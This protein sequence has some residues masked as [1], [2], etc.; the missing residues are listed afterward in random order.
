MSTHR[1]LRLDA[2][3]DGIA[4]GPILAPRTLPGEEVSGT[5]EGRVLRDIRI[6]TPSPDRRSPPCPHYRACGGC[7][8]QHAS[9]G[10]TAEWKRGL[11]EAALRRHGLSAET[12]PVITSP[13]RSRRRSFADLT[14]RAAHLSR[15]GSGLYA[16]ANL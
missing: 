13:D 10:F 8:L 5:P 12:G 15:T 1:I 4:E 14:P 9:D 7:Q 6:L 11:V 3:G 16:R 2:R